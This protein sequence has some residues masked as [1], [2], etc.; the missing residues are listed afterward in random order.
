MFIRISQAYRILS[1]EE[2]R[3]LYDL[4]GR[5]GLALMEVQNFDV[6]LEGKWWL[7]PRF[8]LFY[9]LA[10]RFFEIRYKAYI[11]FYHFHQWLNT[12]TS[13]AWRRRCLIFIETLRSVLKGAT[14]TSSNTP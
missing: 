14:F 6:D 13:V 11:C 4:Y 3:K 10:D 9:G 7:H 12:T 5:G 8:G 2:D 1:S